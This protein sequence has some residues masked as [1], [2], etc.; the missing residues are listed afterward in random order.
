MRHTY[1][2]VLGKPFFSVGGQVHNSSGYPIGRKGN[3]QY[4]E[5]C[6]RSFQSLKAIGAN[7]IAVPVCWDAFEP[8]EGAYDVSYV[9]TVIDNIRSHGLH[10]ILLWFGTW[11]N[12]QMEYTPA[13]VKKDRKRFPRILCKDGTETT[14]LSPHSR[15]NLEQDAKAFCALM[16][17][18]RDYDE[19]Q[20]TILAVQVENEPGIYAAT[21][22]DFG[23]AGT[24][25]FEEAVPEEVR[26]TAETAEGAMH[27]SWV[28]NG[29]RKQGNWREVFGPFGA[30]LCTAW[31][32]AG[33]IDEIAA[34]GKEIYDIF[35]YTNV[36]MDRNS[37]YGWNLAGLEYPC[38]G[39]VSKCLPLWHC[40]CGHLDAI[41]PDIYE[42]NPEAV[43]KAYG[44]Y[45]EEEQGWPLYVPESGL[46]AVN[47]TCMFDAVGNRQAI[48]YHV[49]GIES[50]L[51][52]EGRLKESAE[53]V[54]HSFTMLTAA[55]GLLLPG[56]G[57]R[58]LYAFCQSVGQDSCFLEVGNR[59]CRVSFAGVAMDYAGWVPFDYHH[60]RD[61]E[62][63]PR[64]VPVSLTEETA[65]GLL[66]CM[67]EDEFF[68]VGHKVRL[69][70]T[71]QAPEDGSLPAG[72]MN[73]QHLAHG[74]EFLCLEE[75]H[76]EEGAFVTDRIRSGDEARHGIWAQYDCGVVHF[77][78]G[79]LQGRN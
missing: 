53:P 66:F 52:P 56:G 36:W 25:A 55:A 41:C 73:G 57:A 31:A 21:R 4:E 76:F 35:M 63:E 22:R 33:Y 77:I 58:A 64:R 12:G 61:S 16:E 40:A 2:S 20:G 18:I 19:K 38:G 24:K 54:M 49:F 6:E 59:R 51:D 1:F 27:D 32:I 14:V 15:S 42:Q 45:G 67:G 13:W 43:R 10:G 28:K 26:R 47:A 48:G 37:D 71:E 7:T 5:D 68:L 62:G 74:M 29:R 46:T 69:F 72:W 50:C 17:I 70:F 34:R 79:T 23:E 78:L 60:G 9:H 30:E 8:E 39:A 65:R 75:G 44:I 11:K 3:R